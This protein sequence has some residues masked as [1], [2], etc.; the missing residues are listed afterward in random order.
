MSL[1]D[2]ARSMAARNRQSDKHR[3]EVVLGRAANE[4]GLTVSEAT[5]HNWKT[6]TN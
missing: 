5:S 2:Q 1:K 6:H 4:V 3:E